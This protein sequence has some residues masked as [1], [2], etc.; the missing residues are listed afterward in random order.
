MGSALTPLSLL[1]LSAILLSQW[2]LARLVL[3]RFRDRPRELR[4]VRA[5]LFAGAAAV[6]PGL[7][8]G[9]RSI[10]YRLPLAPDFISWWHAAAYAWACLSAATFVLW[11]LR[12][13]LAPPADPTRRQ[14]LRAAAN[15][16]IAAP[17]AVTGYGF[18]VER[19]NL[20]VR[21]VDLPVSELPQDLEGLRLLQISDIH[22]SA[23]LSESEFSRMI[24]AANELR[25]HLAV[26][27]GDL[28]SVPRDP[29]DACLRQIARL[30]ATAGVIGCMGNH[31]LYTRSED[32]AEREGARLGIDFLRGRAR[33][34]RF[35]SGIVNFGGVDYQRMEQRGRYL[36]GA[37]RLLQPGAANVLLSHNPDVFPVAARQGWDVTLAG[38]THGG[39]VTVEIVEQTLNPARFLTP[40]VYGPYGSITTKRRSSLYV[41]RGLGTIG[42]PVR[43]GA[44]PEIAVIRLAKSREEGR[45]AG[46]WFRHS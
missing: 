30:R 32:Y 29:M 23:F 42:I 31:E 22:L 21:E 36:A 46:D 39:Q 11:R 38:H 4:R 10:A 13:R 17:A 27:T 1:E 19:T 12:A 9:L 37:E 44:L 34:F 40:Y 45:A 6:V 8:L 43:L 25:A 16:V 14:W 7:L 33:A 5:A 18:F 24:D 28:I 2:G 15:A 35:G 20:K 26:V 41:T 3:K